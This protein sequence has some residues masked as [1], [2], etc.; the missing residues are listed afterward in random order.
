V[1]DAIAQM[2]GMRSSCNT[3]KLT[4]GYHLADLDL[5]SRS[6]CV[7]VM[8][9]GQVVGIVTERDIVRLSAQQQS[10]DRLTMW[11]VMTHPVVTLRESAFTDLFSAM[12]LLQQHHI[13]HLPILNDQ[14][15]LLGFITYDSLQHLA[16]PIGLL[17]LRQVAEV[18]THDVVCTAPDSSV[19]AIAQ[20]MS[21]HNIS[22]VVIVKP[23][24]DHAGVHPIPVGIL[25]ERD[26]VQCQALGLDL[27]RC[28]AEA[29]MSTPMFSVTPE[30]SLWTVQQVMEQRFI[31][32]VAVTGAQGELLGIVTRTDL[33]QAL[34]PLELYKLAEGLEAQVVQL[35]AEKVQLLENRTAELEQQVEARTVALTINAQREK[36][37]AQIATSIRNSLNL[38]EILEVCVAEVRAF[39]ECDRVLVYQFQPDWSGLIIAESVMEGCSSALGNQIH[40]SCFQ[41]QTTTFYNSD[42]PIIAND[43]Y[44]TD[45]ADC[46]IRLL[47]RYQV[48]ANLV[49]PIRVS[50]HLWGL[51]IG[52]QCAEP[53]EWRTEDVLLLQDISV[54]LAIA[55]QQAT[56]YQQL[57]EE[58]DARRQAEACLRESEQRYATLVAAA[59]V[60]IF[61]TDATGNYTYVNDRWCQITGR[62]AESVLGEEWWQGV[63][64][65]DRNRLIAEWNQSTQKNRLFQFEYRLQPRDGRVIWVYGQVVTERD[66]AGQPKGYVGTITDISD[67]VRSEAAL[68]ISEAHQRALI[69]AIPDLIMRVNRDGIYLEF[70]TNPT[71]L[72]LGNLSDLVG[73]HVSQTLPPDLTQKRLDYIHLALQ[74]GLIQIYEHD[75]SIDGTV[76]IEEVRV[77]PYSDDEVLLLV[78]DISDRKQAELALQ[79]SEA[80]SRAILMAIPDLMFRVGADGT[81]RE[82]VSQYQDFAAVPPN[83]DLVG[84][85]LTESLPKEHA[86]RHL[87]YLQKALQTGELQVYEH[88]LPIGDRLQDEEVRVVKSDEDEALFMIRDISDRKRAERQLQNL[89]EGTAATTGQNFFPALVQYIAEALD[90]SYALVAE[91]IDDT[92]HILAF[93]ANGVLQPVFSYSAVGTPCDTVLRNGKFYCHSHISELFPDNSRLIEMGAESCLGMALYDTQGKAI[94]SLCILD[95]QP[96]RDL[97]RAENLLSVFAARA[98]AELER[99]LATQA[100]ERLNQELEQ[101]VEA[102]TAA[103]QANEERWQFILR[104]SNDGIWDWDVTTNRVFYSSR[105]KM[106]RGFAD[107]EIGD[108]RQEWVNGIHPEDYDRVMAAVEKHFAHKTRFF[109]MEYRVRRKDGSYI[110]ILDRGQALW[111]ESGQ[112]VRMSGSETD[113]TIRKQVEEALWDS[114]RRYATLATVA[115][116][117]IF[118]FNEPLNCTY[119]SDR[120][121]EMTGR[122][123]RS[124]FGKGWMEALHPDDR[125]RLIAQ[126]TEE[127]AH[128]PSGREAFYQGE[129]R[130][131]RTDGKVNWFYVQVVPEIDFNDNIVGYIGTLT[132][133]TKR[134]QAEHIIHQQAEQ[135]TIIR[136]ITQRIR[137][138]LNI[139]TIFDTACHEIRQ[140][141][142]ADR[143]GIFKFYPESNFDDGEFVA[144]SVVDGYASVVAIRV[145][146]HCF[147]KNYSSLY[148]NG[149]FF[150]VDDIYS[151]GLEDCH[152]HVLAQFGVR[153]NL[154]M[155]LL[156]GEQLWGLLC[157]HQCA[158]SRQ[159]QPSEISLTQ[160]IANQLAIAI[161]QASL[162]EQIQAELWVRQQAEAEIARQLRR[163]QTLGAIAQRIRESLD[164]S[165]ILATVTQQ[166]KDVLHGDRVIVFRLFPDGTSRIVEEAVSCEFPTLKHCQW[167]NEVWSQDILDCYWQGQPRI[168]PDVMNDSWTDCLVN[169]SI[170]GQIKSKIVAPIL[171]EVRGSE[172]HRWASPQET[173]K[174]WGILVIHA[175][176]EKR[177][178]QESE[179]QLLQQIANQLAIAIQQASLFEQLQQ[180]LAERQQ[181]QQQLTERN[182]QLA[183]SNEELARATRLKDEFLANMSH[184]LRTPLN[185]ILGMTEGLQDQVFGQITEQQRRALQTV[186]RSSSH[187]LELINDI[188]DVAKIESGQI[189]LDVGSTA[190]APLCQS[191]LAFIKQQALKKRIQLDLKLPP[192]LPDLWVDERRI[193]QVLINLLNNA[194]KFTPA[195][196]QIRLEISRHKQLTVRDLFSDGDRVKVEQTAL[197]HQSNLAVVSTPQ[198]DLWMK[199]YLRISVIDT[200]IG[201]AP[202][203]IDKLFQPFVQIDSAL[204]R[205]YAGTGLG[206]ALVKRIVELHGGQVEV[207][208][209]IG[210]GSCFAINLP[211]ATSASFSP[212][213]DLPI[214][215]DIDFRPSEQKTVSPLILLTEDNEANIM[216]LSSYLKAKGYRLLIARNGQEAIALTQAN[217]PDLILMDIQMPGMDG[218]EAIQQIRCRPDSVEVPIIAL[219]ALAMTGDRDRCLTAGAN[220]YLSK[221]VKL[222]E[223]VTLIQHL[224]TNNP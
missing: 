215:S 130:H 74:T 188:L 1:V 181:A 41:A 46:H 183:I 69:K 14:D 119:V 105:W 167:E 27:E 104:G 114:E 195:G 48:K 211:C 96:I 115:P 117:A 163:Q 111:D 106:M 18:M 216:T 147:G 47:E 134:K 137:Q 165:E 77:V 11:Q 144:E 6:S 169:Y 142:Q 162:Y 146:D 125:D 173:N 201:I 68:Q 51:L 187:L 23:S 44:T 122:P 129:G 202:E 160:Q 166:V 91:Q 170:E 109:E 213:L 203:H 204:N 206:L 89:I 186:E 152:G 175:C 90:V 164:L 36:L 113:I 124:A 5:E 86:E 100:L 193:R 19:L 141:I 185:A 75:L 222:R 9:D 2:S 121:S 217:P 76:W 10:L 128:L 34:N 178:W 136:E 174:L 171:Q 55:L 198:E 99:E 221:P 37:V 57:Q 39:L 157:V 179:A 42:Q 38:Q 81:Y 190:I 53:R 35:E 110:W 88:I 33:L 29:V 145:H 15:E 158:T 80:K 120:W 83:V 31:R 56:L 154:V 148:A 197:D 132:D 8:E 94:G 135:E 102:R 138:S 131:L 98:A 72:V 116:V 70:V 159:W 214:N 189:E 21:N 64:P 212:T 143:V 223:L 66:G 82:F 60:G 218:L 192:D 127:F 168:V 61:R 172:I 200:G 45:Y 208:S 22:S 54:Q 150:A 191:S 49:V 24:D 112:V 151:N 92:L 79:H 71:F 12:Y 30:E 32:R 63:F 155:P 180:E 4:E 13:H 126:W 95:Q 219:T 207:A 84:R 196:G 101:K 210:V 209:E 62:T 87:Q 97:Q 103:L 50:E 65:D 176:R 28:T 78:R 220:E 177:V 59:P 93:W 58:L 194:V 205:Q 16:Q 123:I 7:I 40:D 108:S 153:A 43:I 3:T 161:Q 140:V 107:D 184:E 26:L 73:T 133:I 85:A 67:R 118:R 149:R 224:L 156:C 20:H 25:T 139:Q 17:R 199:D 52:H 182:Q